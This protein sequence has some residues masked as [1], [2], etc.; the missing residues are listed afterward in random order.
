MS[1]GLAKVGW[2]EH[3]FTL[4]DIGGGGRDTRTLTLNTLSQGEREEV[5]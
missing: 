5:I 4:A 3:F 2:S 1:G